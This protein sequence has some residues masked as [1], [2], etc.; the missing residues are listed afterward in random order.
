[1]LANPE[2]TPLFGEVLGIGIGSI[3][4]ALIQQA[5]MDLKVRRKRV[6]TSTGSERAGPTQAHPAV[7]QFFFLL[8]NGLC[9]FAISVLAENSDMRSLGSDEETYEITHRGAN[10]GFGNSQGSAKLRPNKVG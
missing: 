9:Y 7:P 5:R 4:V 10:D 8:P 1:M 6:V 2:C 3:G